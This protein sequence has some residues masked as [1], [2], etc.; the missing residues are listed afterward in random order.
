MDD[1]PSWPE[2]RPYV[3]AAFRRFPDPG[4][5]DS[6]A[7]VVASGGRVSG[8]Y[9]A[10]SD[11]DLYAGLTPAA[12]G[13]Q[14]IEAVVDGVV[15]QLSELPHALVADVVTHLGEHL[16]TRADRRQAEMFARYGKIA[17][18]LVTGTVVRCT[19]EG[20]AVLGGLSRDAFRRIGLSVHGLFVARMLEDAAGAVACAD[21]YIGVRAAALA[22]DAAL[23]CLL[24]E[25][26]DLHWGD[27]LLW[28]R[29]AAHPGLAAA[30]RLAADS[31]RRLYSDLHEPDKA[32]AA[33]RAACRTASVLASL[34]A[35]RVTGATGVPGLPTDACT[36]RPTDDRVLPFTVA[37][38]FR[39]GLSLLAPR[40][41]VDL[42]AEEACHE[43]GLVVE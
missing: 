12:R 4:R 43:L 27:A 28:R 38:N 1:H 26:G 25:A 20:A 39:D 34:A 29:L 30:E 10:Y 6:Y 41:R 3:E 23:D 19:A 5:H 35:V 32:L 17:S 37:V 11:V 21:P 13:D 42:T 15:V 24:H 31:L 16:L 22:L 8:Y 7:F 40:S 36:G 2:H 33:V 18:R 9:H 14:E